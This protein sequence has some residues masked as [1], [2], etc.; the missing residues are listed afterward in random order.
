MARAMSISERNLRPRRPALPPDAMFRLW[1][2]A[3]KDDH[4]DVAD[5]IIQ[6]VFDD[7]MAF[8]RARAEEVVDLI[9]RRNSAARNAFGVLFKDRQVLQRAGFL[10][11]ASMFA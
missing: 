5:E 11:A 6:K 2:A 4:E 1:R 8:D 7:M 9:V 3:I 10:A